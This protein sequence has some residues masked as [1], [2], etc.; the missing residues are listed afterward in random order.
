LKQ[1]LDEAGPIDFPVRVS[2][3]NASESSDK[4]PARTTSYTCKHFFK[5]VENKTHKQ[6]SVQ[7]KNSHPPRKHTTSNAISTN[8]HDE[9]Q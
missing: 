9:Q 8:D 4:K 6:N 1:K 7:P 5:F 3:N 2:S